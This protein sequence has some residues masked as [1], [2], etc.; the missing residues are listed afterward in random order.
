MEDKTL[1]TL[2]PLTDKDIIKLAKGKEVLNNRDLK[3]NVGGKVPEESGG[4]Y[5]PAIF[6]SP[7]QCK[8]GV[9]RLKTGDTIKVCPNCKTIVFPTTEEWQNNFAFYRLRNPYI[10]PYKVAKFMS[11]LASYGMEPI[12]VKGK[13]ASSWAGQLLRIWDSAYKVEPTDE[14]DEAIL[15]KDDQFYKLTVSEVDDYTP[16][17]EIGLIGI[18]ELQAYKLKKGG[19]QIDFS[20]YLNTCLPIT[21]TAFRQYNLLKLEKP[22]LQIDDKTLQYK[23]IIEFDLLFSMYSSSLIDNAIDRATMLYNINMLIGIITNSTDLLKPGKYHTVRENLRQRVKKSMRANIIPALDIDMNHIK[24]PRSLAYAALNGDIKTRLMEKYGLESYEANKE[25]NDQ[26]QRALEVLEDIISTSMAIALRNPTLHK[27]N[28]VALHPVLTDDPAIGI[29]IDICGIMGG[30]F[31][32]DQ[33]AVFIV[34]EPDICAQLQHDMMPEQIWFYEKE[35]RPTF[36]PTHEI[37]YGLHLA[38]TYGKPTN[39]EFGTFEELENAYK[40]QKVNYND[41]VKLDDRKSSYGRAKVEHILHMDLDAGLGED[42]PID[43]KNI[44]KIVSGMSTHRRRAEEMHELTTF[45]T[46]IVTEVGMDT[47]PFEELYDKND[48]KVK[49]LI[50]SSD[51]VSVKYTKLQNYL[52]EYIDG[53]VANLEGSSLPSMLKGS[54]RVKKAQLEEIYSPAIYID[55]GDVTISSRSLFGGLTERD[56]VAKGIDNRQIQQLKRFGVPVSGYATRQV[57]MS[58]MDIMFDEREASPD[59]IGLLI[60]LK[61]AAGRTRINGTKVSEDLAKRAKADEMV[62]VK[63]CVNHNDKLVYA[64]EINQKD[65]KEKDGAAIGV[66]FAMSLTEA[67]TQDA[68]SWKHGGIQQSFEAQHIEAIRSGV[69]QSY[70]NEFLYIETSD[71]QVDKYLMCEK[72]TPT[73]RFG[74]YVRAKQTIATSRRLKQLYDQLADYEA[75]MGITNIYD[76]GLTRESGRGLVMRFAPCDG[77]ISYPDAYHVKIGNGVTVPVNRSELYYYPEGYQVKTGQAICSGVLDMGYFM[78]LN[79]NTQDQF[80]ALK[81]QMSDIYPSAETRSEVYE[82]TFKCLRQSGFSVREAYYGT[83][84]FINRMYAGSTK[85]GLEGFFKRGTDGRDVIE[86]KDSI[87][88]PLVL[89]FDVKD[90]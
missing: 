36:T 3:L 12:K 40:E 59:K 81:H 56:F 13:H 17:N 23:A 22:I 77:E 37:L 60:P 87:I 28:L 83:D 18:Y 82:V 1:F 14:E 2:T 54:G 90:I 34:T 61:E 73:V 7:K 76:N 50:A 42:N 71:G 27:Y 4:L 16:F 35:A 79:H 29:P 47:P 52:N 65:L 63:S 8:C 53:K 25:Y 48:P 67:K 80:D 85:K 62:R 10:F 66:S 31:D 6:G 33:M 51:P 41:I 84:N 43:V 26:T 68:L 11:V 9:T 75:F 78:Q 5:D 69:V 24:L 86:V 70:D 45:A 74:E 46:E 15:V 57:V 30:D 72:V 49:E 20:S 21:S 44:N 89:G 19:A 39:K 32:G 38:T 88:L 55:D 58:Q 64:D